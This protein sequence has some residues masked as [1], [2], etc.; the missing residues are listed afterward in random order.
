MYAVT[1]KTKQPHLITD[2]AAS[3][4]L[5]GADGYG[6]REITVGVS[7][8]YFTVKRMA[9]FIDIQPSRAYS[10]LISKPV[11]IKKYQRT[12]PLNSRPGQPLISDPR[13]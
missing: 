3:M 4:R 1:P 5:S 13:T 12:R 11:L 8:V 2:A 7:P 6:H 9:I 10:C